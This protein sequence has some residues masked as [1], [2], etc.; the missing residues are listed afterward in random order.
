MCRSELAHD[1]QLT[2]TVIELQRINSIQQS[3]W[4]P[5]SYSGSTKVSSVFYGSRRFINVHIR[6]PMDP[7][8]RQMKPSHPTSFMTLW[9]PY[10]YELKMTDCWHVKSQLRTMNSK[11]SERVTIP[12]RAY[13]LVCAF[14][15]A[16]T[17]YPVPHN[18]PYFMS[19]PM[20]VQIY[21]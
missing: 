13:V 12:S 21:S 9:V 11:S 18:H 7:I 3:P 2:A 10:N 1:S 20:Q 4:E 14:D 16:Q 8:L 5:L 15:R 6:Q 17:I 19:P